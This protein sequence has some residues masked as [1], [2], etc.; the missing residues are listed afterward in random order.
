MLRNNMRALNMNP[1]AL[2]A[3]S[4]GTMFGTY[5]I[6][7]NNNWMLKNMM[8]TAF[9]GTTSATLLPLIHAYAAPVIFDALIATSFTVGSLG[10]VAYNAPSEQFLNWGGPLALGLGGMLGISILSMVYPGSAMLHNAWLYGGLALFSAYLM[11]DTQK[12]MANAKSQRVF[13]PINQSIHVYLDAV[14]LFVRFVM[15]FGNQ[16]K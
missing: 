11:Y 4:L 7:Y 10:T 2:L 14:Q 16:K 6:D 15:I 12:I 1:W 3:L 9:I 5:S 8:F 13:D